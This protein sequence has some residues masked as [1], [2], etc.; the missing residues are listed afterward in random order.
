[1]TAHADSA[2]GR[3]GASGRRREAVGER[4]A[5]RAEPD[6]VHPDIETPHAEDERPGRVASTRRV[7]DE[8]STELDPIVVYLQRVGD[9]RLLN[10][11]GEQT[12]AQQ[13]EEGTQA[14][15]EA[16]LAMPLGR[17]ELLEAGERL[18]EDVAYRCEVMDNED[19]HEFEDTSATKD[20]ERFAQQ[21]ADARREWERAQKAVAKKKPSASELERYRL[22]QTA[23]FRLFREFGFGYRVLIKVLAVVRQHTEELKRAWRQ[24]G[25][26]A[27]GTGAEPAELLASVKRN[28][29]P[30]TLT[31]TS[32][33]RLK[34]IAESISGIESAMGLDVTSFLALSRALDE[35]QARAEQ[36]RAVM[37]LANL[38]LVVSIAKRYMNRSLPLLDLI[39]EGNIGLM[40]AVEKFEWRRG[41]KFSTY[42][43]WWIRQSITRAIAD[44]ARTIRIPIHLV[45]LLNRITRARIQLEQQFQREPGHDEIA[46][47]LELPEEVVSRTIRF[48]RTTVSLEA[49]VGDDESELSDFIAD[50]DA[51]DPEH[52]AEREALRRVTREL[53]SSLPQREAKILS[54]RFGICERRSYTL[55]EVG[56]DMELTRERIRQIEA[57]ALEKLRC[58]RRAA[59]VLQ[60]WGEAVDLDGPRPES[61]AA[62][63]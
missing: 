26:L 30:R 11:L 60:A 50:E 4:R 9:V 53:L 44:Q 27:S 51:I 25:R 23:L 5:E 31:A 33:K 22:A 47:L 43:T 39:Q 37:I 55:E 24:L 32:Q 28:A 38:R 8:F 13:I 48:S 21:L 2:R 45:E 58:P 29:L 54:K 20:L 59:E 57:K 36:G 6:D 46:A 34:G 1:M 12:V 15:F 52:S 56:R 49:P 10:R 3:K 62:T 16:L 17:R 35:G 41:H 63:D 61:H 18:L 42:A 40:K 14:V 19:G 7:G